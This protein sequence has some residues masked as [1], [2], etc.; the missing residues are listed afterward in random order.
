MS[1]LPEHYELPNLEDIDE[2]E[3]IVEKRLWAVLKA[4]TFLSVVGLAMTFTYTFNM[5]AAMQRNESYAYGSC[6]SIAGAQT[7][8]NCNSNPHT[9]AW[10]LKQLNTGQG[11][12]NV[13]FLDSELGSGEKSGYTF[14]LLAGGQNGRDSASSSYWSWSAAAWPVSYK[15]TGYR[16]FYVD[17]TG[18]VRGEDIGGRMG[19]IEMSSVP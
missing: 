14:V 4:T 2:I 15:S 17:E 18:V 8:Y 10:T 12:G 1:K 3:S 7:D 13:A 9:Y 6:K 11:A 16:S 19:R 5:K